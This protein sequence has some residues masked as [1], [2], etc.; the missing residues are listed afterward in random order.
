MWRTAGTVDCARSSWPAYVWLWHQVKQTV[1][2][3]L[4]VHLKSHACMN[5][6]MNQG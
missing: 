4:R 6:C 2:A 1:G 5:V 3:L